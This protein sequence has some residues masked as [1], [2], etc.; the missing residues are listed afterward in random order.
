MDIQQLWDSF[1]GLYIEMVPYLAFGL[2][3]AGILH[4]TVK[5]SFILNHFGSHGLWAVIKASLLGVP[6]PLCS[7]SVVPTALSLKKHG[8]SNGATLSFLIS[9]PQTG[10]ESI[11]AT[12]GMMGPFFALFRPFVAFVTGILGGTITSVA[13]PRETTELSEIEDTTVKRTPLEKLK[14]LFRYG[15]IELMDDIGFNL[16]VGIAISAI[17]TEVLPT[18]WFTMFS[19]R[20]L[21]E[22]LIVL[23]G[24][25]PLYVCATAS[26]P[27]AAALLIQGVSPGAALIFLMAGP[28]TNAAT[29]TLLGGKLG[30]KMV[31]IYLSVIVFSSLAFGMLLNAADSSFDLNIRENAV[32]KYSSATGIDKHAAMGHTAEESSEQGIVEGGC[33]EEEDGVYHDEH[34]DHGNSLWYKIMAIIFTIPL[35]ISVWKTKLKV[36]LRLLFKKRIDR[37]AVATLVYSVGGVTCHNCASHVSDAAKLLSNVADATVDVDRMELTVIGDIDESE[38]ESAVHEAGYQC[39]GIIRG[40]NIERQFSVT[41]MTCKNCVAHVTDAVTSL[42]DIGTVKVCLDESC[43]VVTGIESDEAVIEAV[44]KAGYKIERE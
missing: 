40:T 1:I 4:V 25:V 29:I 26:I 22:M 7:C 10:V 9:T 5:R 21:I 18:E 34:D 24:A 38:I 6:L 17:I 35:L 30:K 13:T 32:A 19:D 37:N 11:A 27:I 44:K 43:M 41:G 14:E 33:Y 2:F 31:G 15:F 23:I 28:A 16:L 8:A 42:K 3:V 36:P 39:K 12:W 20:P